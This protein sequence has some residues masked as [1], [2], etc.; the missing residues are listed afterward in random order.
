MLAVL[1]L[2]PATVCP[3]AP[4]SHLVAHRALVHCFIRV[5]SHIT[6]VSGGSSVGPLGQCNSNNIN[7]ILTQLS[8]L[9]HIH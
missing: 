4:A 5:S 1:E 8:V 6:T 9:T 3:A 2:I 7:V